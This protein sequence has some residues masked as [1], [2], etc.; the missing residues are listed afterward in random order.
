MKKYQILWIFVAV[1]GLTSCLDFDDPID[2]LNFNQEALEDSV[3]HG[4]PTK[5]DYNINITEAQFDDALASLQTYLK[6]AK[7]GQYSMRGGKN[8]DYP[9]EHAY[10]RQFSLGPDNYAQYTTVPHY[11]FMYGTL[12]TSYDVSAEFNGGPNSLYLLVKNAMI[13]LLN[14]PAIDSI[15]EMKA[16]YLLMFDY[17]T[18]E[19][20]DIHGALPYEEFLVNKQGAP[21]T[22]N[23]AEHIYKKI[24][25][26]I[27]LIT[28]CLRHYDSR[29][30]WYKT[31]LQKLMDE[32]L[33]IS[34]DNYY[35]K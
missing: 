9:G 31:K 14:H 10:Q 35:S 23:G 12:Q 30:E 11:D 19:I 26:H 15:P 25:S 16:I 4:N 6:Q 29:P 24:I 8:G 32:N 21:F 13:P 17:S 20:A 7:S 2:T 33:E 1:L 34:K 18:Q 27:D 3:Y 22:Y 5:I 28:A